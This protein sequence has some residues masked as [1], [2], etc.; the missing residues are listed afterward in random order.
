M[1]DKKQ[2]FTDSSSS[3]RMQRVPSKLE[4]N[5]AKPP[6]MQAAPQKPAQQAKP[7]AKKD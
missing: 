1:T 4:T 2:N 6:R 3:P 5:S 7:P